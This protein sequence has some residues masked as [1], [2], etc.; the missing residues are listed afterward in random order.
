MLSYM[1]EATNTFTSY[2][3]IGHLLTTEHNVDPGLSVGRN[4]AFFADL[5]SG[6]RGLSLGYGFRDLVCP[7]W[8]IWIQRYKK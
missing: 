4:Q 3:S 8:L 5:V 1:F 2:G 6:G 7:F